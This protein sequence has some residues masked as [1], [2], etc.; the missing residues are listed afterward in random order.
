MLSGL[1]LVLLGVTTWALVT[2]TSPEG[3][4]GPT[5]WVATDGDDEGH[6][7]RD[8]PWATLQHA[9]DVATPGATVNVRGGVYPQRMAVHVSG[10]PGRP[11]IFRNAPGEHPV[12]DGSSIQVGESSRR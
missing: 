5:Y 2:R 7:S 6:G 1:S 11:I 10:V 8:E 12:L 3:S 4:A 9:A